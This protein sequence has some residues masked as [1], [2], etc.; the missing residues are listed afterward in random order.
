MFYSN[1]VSTKCPAGAAAGQQSR[2]KAQQGAIQTALDRGFGKAVQHIEAEIS[3][4]DRLSLAEQE[5]LLAALDQLDLIDAV[6]PAPGEGDL[7]LPAT[8]NKITRTS[9]TA[10]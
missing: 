5:V 10:P 3:V 7:L 2:R 8:P 9:R 1:V 6:A 4:Y